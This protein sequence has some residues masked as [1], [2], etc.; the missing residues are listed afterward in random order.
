MNQK[1]SV[2]VPV[3]NAENYLNRCIK[4]VLTQT[5][6]DWQ[7]VLV[8]DGSKDESLKVCQKYADLDNRIRVIHQENAGPGIAR[9]TGIAAAN[10]DYVVFIDSDDY[11]EKDYFQLL[12]EHDEDVVFINVRNVDEQGHILNEKYMTK[13]RRLS[14]DT[15][16]RRQMT[17]R[18]DW[19]GVRKALKINV[20]RDYNVKYTNH[21]IGEEALYSFLVL[22]YAKSVA[23]IDA[24]LYNY[25]QR[26]DSQSHIKVDD[27]WGDVALS[28]KTK[29]LEMGL[30]P[31]YADTINAFLLTASAV[32]ANN[33]AKN[34]TFATYL[35]EVKKCRK[36]LD[37]AIDCKYH[38]DRVSMSVKARMIGRLLQNGFY[39]LIWVIVKLR[40]IMR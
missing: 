33:I 13:N 2:I 38:I 3:Y 24:P 26:G 28:M 9:N 23:F 30:Y 29:I 34:H 31:K 6:T 4:S 32:S 27:P 36:R 37:K 20:I 8:D 16:L 40:E 1:I 11:V 19:G 22:W 5:Y 17:G 7:M 12:S 10:G 35:T 21:K 25:V 39:G 18:I 14:K 15:I